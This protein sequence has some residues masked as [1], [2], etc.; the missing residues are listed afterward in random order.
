MRVSTFNVNGLQSRLPQLRRF[1]EQFQPDVVCLQEIKLPD[2]RFPHDAIAA[3]GYPHQ[4]VAGQKAYNG[5]AILSRLP[6][7]DPQRGFRDGPPDPEQRLVAATVDGIR[8][9]GLYAPNGTQVGSDRYER[10][11]AWYAR[12]TE[13]L[14][15]YHQPSDPLLLTGDFNVVPDDIDAWDPFGSEGQLLCTE[16]EREAFATLLA[17]GLHD[18]YRAL[19]PTDVGF[20]WWDYQR[21]AYARNQGLRID[22]VLL[23]APLLERA[24]RVLLHREVRGWERPSDHAPV[25]VDLD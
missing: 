3:M 19:Y 22:H 1:C 6:L 14:R 7:D 21:R 9:Y 16:P 10:K 15:S 17:F 24:R 8:I 4:L 25:S 23:T 12:L 2:A 5:V 18:A 13:E 11:L 20:T